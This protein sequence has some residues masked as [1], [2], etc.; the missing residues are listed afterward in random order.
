MQIS[1]KNIKLLAELE[2]LVG[3]EC[4][5]PNS[6]DGYRNIQGQGYRYPVTIPYE[7]SG[8]GAETKI[9]WKLSDLT[10]IEPHHLIKSKYKFGSNHLY[11]GRGIENILT[12]I[13][14]RYGIDFD[15]LE[16]NYQKGE[17]K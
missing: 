3:K 14:N 13:E 16:T 8:K 17:D 15:E 9:E 5:N 10:W 7:Q 11:I 2:Y 6:L 1:Y 12:F 4:F